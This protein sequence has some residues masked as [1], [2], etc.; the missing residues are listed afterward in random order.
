[1]KFKTKV[2]LILIVLL[3]FMLALPA[4]AREVEKNDSDKT[5]A[6]LGAG[7]LLLLLV[8]YSVIANYRG[9]P[10]TCASCTCGRAKGDRRTGTSC[11]GNEN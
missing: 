8:V 3:V 9:E 6:L 7:I 11:A 5:G 2:Y 1:M 4:F 10:H